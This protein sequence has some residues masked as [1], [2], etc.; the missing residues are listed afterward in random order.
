M[1]SFPLHFLP[2]Y[3]SFT[4]KTFLTVSHHNLLCW[5]AAIFLC[6]KTRNLVHLQSFLIFFYCCWISSTWIVASCH[7]VAI[8]HWVLELSN[9]FYLPCLSLVVSDQ[10]QNTE[11][12]SL[13]MAGEL[14]RQLLTKSVTLLA[15]NNTCRPFTRIWRAVFFLVEE[16][17]CSGEMLQ[18]FYLNCYWIS[19]L[20]IIQFH[21]IFEECFPFALLSV[22]LRSHTLHWRSSRFSCLPFFSLKLI[23][24]YLLTSVLL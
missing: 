17:Q 2:S 16:K 4:T 1:E 18:G 8:C 10:L 9:T 14:Q 11:L 24:L 23:Q 6:F 3:D 5:S 20:P 15:V 13:N 21:L 7:F 19:Y 22:Q 12:L